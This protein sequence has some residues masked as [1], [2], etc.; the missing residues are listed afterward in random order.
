MPTVCARLLAALGGQKRAWHSL[1]LLA[2]VGQRVGAG[3][4]WPLSHPSKP[5]NRILTSSLSV[6]RAVASVASSLCP[7]VTE[8]DLEK[9]SR[10]GM[11]DTLL[12]EIQK[13]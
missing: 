1:E 7:V 9:D 12:P 8:E 10:A 11:R 13:R 6:G 2:V 3:I 4:S 5:Q